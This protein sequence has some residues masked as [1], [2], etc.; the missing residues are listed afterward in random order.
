[1]L[2]GFE[3]KELV[4]AESQEIARVMIQI[5]ELSDPIQKSSR[6]EIA[7][8]PVEQF[9]RKGAIWPNEIARSQELAPDRIGELV[10][11][12]P[13]GAGQRARARGPNDAP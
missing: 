4:E 12:P 2:R 6:R 10:S 9:G 5:S 8:D 1:M 3:E 13:F 11:G 7:Q